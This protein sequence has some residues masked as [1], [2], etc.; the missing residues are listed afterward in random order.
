MKNIIIEFWDGKSKHKCN[1]ICNVL[2]G[3]P[4]R[5][6]IAPAKNKRMPNENREFTLTLCAFAVK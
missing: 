2:D 5:N 3:H 1:E 4:K 6:K